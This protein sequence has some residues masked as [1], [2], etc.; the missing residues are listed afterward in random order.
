MPGETRDECALTLHSIPYRQCLDGRVVNVGWRNTTWFQFLIA[1]VLAREARLDNLR[2]A[3]RVSI[4]Y[5]QCLSRG[6]PRCHQGVRYVS[7]PY[8]QCLG[9]IGSVRSRSSSNLFD[10]CLDH[11]DDSCFVQE[12][13][14]Q[15]DDAYRC[16]DISCYNHQLPPKNKGASSQNC[17]C[18]VVPWY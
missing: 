15:H 13:T 10:K 3:Y 14:R 1:N 18:P 7:I 16:P 11:P 9:T 8:R 2:P 17:Y 6:L 5:R 12:H 4:P